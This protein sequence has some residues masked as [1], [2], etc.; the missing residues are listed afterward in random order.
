MW[1][2][3]RF[4]NATTEK[5]RAKTR[6]WSIACELTSIAAP[7]QSVSRISAKSDIKSSDSGVVLY[8]GILRRPSS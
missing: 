6:F 3:V 1:S 2:C 8:D 5:G 7:A 4:V